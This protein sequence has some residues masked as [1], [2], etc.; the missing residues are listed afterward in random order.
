MK[1][2]VFL[3]VFLVLTL[4]SVSAQ[5]DSLVSSIIAHANDV[6]DQ[7][8]F[9]YAIKLLRKNARQQSEYSA[10]KKALVQM[11]FRAKEYKKSIRH[12]RRYHRKYPANATVFQYHAHSY[13][14]LERS[15]KAEKILKRGIEAMP[16]QGMLYAEL[17]RLMMHLEEYEKALN[18]FEAGISNA[19]NYASNYYWA[20]KIYLESTEE[21]WGLLY[22][23]LFMNLE[24]HTD[25]TAELS[26]LMYKTL[27]KE[28]VFYDDT[29]IAV[30]LSQDANITMDSIDSVSYVSFSQDIVVPLVYQSLHGID[31][32]SIANIDR[33][34]KRFIQLYPLHKNAD[35]YPFHKVFKL[36]QLI[37]DQGHF[38]AYNH[39][40]F[41]MGH[42]EEFQYWRTH[43]RSQWKLFIQ[44]FDDF[45]FTIERSDNYDSSKFR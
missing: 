20:S 31:D 11:F 25:R 23:E 17:G 14:Q 18:Q 39:W 12:A 19:P 34:R 22:G 36:H 13:L 33:F 43:N 35:E 29:A 44:W 32:L 5:K 45:N 37:V 27:N 3:G 8:N 40:L 24:R 1:L 30:K 16:Q 10:L 28:I 7:G 9:D 4:S 21:L 2:T 42:P 38:E 26:E 6:A 41:M 15:E